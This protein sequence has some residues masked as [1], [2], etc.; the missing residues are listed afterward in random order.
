MKGPTATS[1]VQKRASSKPAAI[2][3]TIEIPK[4]SVKTIK[5]GARY[6]QSS[7]LCSISPAAAT[8]ATGVVNSAGLVCRPMICQRIKTT[9]SETAWMPSIRMRRL[10]ARSAAARLA[11][12]RS[13][14]SSAW[15][16]MGRSIVASV[17]NRLRGTRSGLGSGVLQLP[18]DVTAQ[19]G[20]P[21]IGTDRLDVARPPKGDLQELLYTPGPRG[22]HGDSVAEQDR[23]VDRMSDENHRL[24]LF[25]ALHQVEQLLLQDLARLCVERRKRFVHQQHRRIHRERA[26]E[27][28]PLLHPAGELIG[29]ALLEAVEPD[30]MQVVPD[31]FGDLL[32]R[33]AGHRQPEGGVVVDRFPRQEPEVLEHHRDAVL[34]PGHPSTVDLELTVAELDQTGDTAEKRRFPATAR[35]DDAHDLL[36]FDAQGELAERNHCSVEEEPARVVGNDCKIHASPPVRRLERNSYRIDAPVTKRRSTP[37]SPLERRLLLTRLARVRRARSSRSD[38]PRRWPHTP[39]GSRR[40]RRRRVPP[41]LRR[42]LARRRPASLGDA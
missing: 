16:R 12:N 37:P 36:L 40:R 29:I 31:P 7:P 25:G 38:R 28:D 41:V 22:H 24:A 20:E 2:P 5:L 42:S 8:T 21:G 13:S 27:A 3:V 26:Y 10:R 11:R 1:S 4:P 23:L 14:F 30:E 33:G 9:T 19:L 15:I 35:P 39:A 17:T 34:R 18:P 32:L 6:F